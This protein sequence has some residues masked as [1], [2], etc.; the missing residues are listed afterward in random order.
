M[1]WAISQVLREFIEKIQYGISNVY[2]CTSV[3]FQKISIPLPQGV[4]WFETHPTPLKIPVD[5]HI[6]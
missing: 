2:H 4:I 1:L 6:F 3:L 5:S